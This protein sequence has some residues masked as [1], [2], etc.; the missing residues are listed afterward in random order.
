MTPE[1]R[2]PRTAAPRIAP[3]AVLPVFLRLEGKRALVVGGSA[4]AAWKAELLA[5]AGATTHVAVPPGETPEPELLALAGAGRVVLGAGYDPSQL[6]GMAVVVFGAGNEAQAALF[7]EQARAAG[8]PC[9]VIDRPAHCSFQFG[10]IVNRSPV[11][12]GISTDGA[13]PILGQAVRRRIEF[14]LPSTLSA[15]AGLAARMRPAVMERLKPGAERCRFWQRFSDLALGANHGADTADLPAGL[16]EDAKVGPVAATG[17]VTLVGAGPGDP[18]LLTV[19]AVRALQAAD[20]ILFDDLVS[21]GVLELARREARRMLVGKRGGRASCAQEDI[22]A[23]ALKLARQGRNVVRLKSGDPM[24][25]GRAGEE[26]AAL[27]AEGIDVAVIPGIT[28]ASA[29]AADLGV[30][31]THRDHAHSVRFVTGHGRDGGL[32]D[33]DW[34]GLADPET[35]LAV[36]MGG[37][38]APAFAASLLA[39]GRHGD[40]PVVLA[41]SVSRPEQ[42]V[43][44]TSLAELAAAAPVHAEG[45]VLVGIGEAFRACA[46]QA[47]ANRTDPAPS[48]LFG[49]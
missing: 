11:V 37:G 7:H 36:Y 20:V 39:K 44:Q 29:L 1:S 32:P 38:T 48:L 12:V 17:R 49:T 33:L 40:T 5:A 23:L 3:L 41:C 45:P 34:Q 9:N 6:H 30:S 15:W 31:L 26:I 18:D 8:V 47:A 22:N 46:A 35:T 21:D 25:F 27:R 10:G 4:A 16:I 24:V 28:A 42:T 13:A 19:K 14:A 43:R 2:Q